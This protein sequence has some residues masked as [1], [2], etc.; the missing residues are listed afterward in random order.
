MVKSQGREE[1]GKTL[2][3]QSR[4]P[5]NSEGKRLDEGVSY[6]SSAGKVWL[7]TAKTHTSLF[8]TSPCLCPISAKQSYCK[9]FFRSICLSSPYTLHR[10]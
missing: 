4:M 2:V 9:I 10:L 1:K 8:L 5:G 3:N 7:L 6:Y